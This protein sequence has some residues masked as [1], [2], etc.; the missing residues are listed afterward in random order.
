MREK[1]ERRKTIKVPE[2]KIMREK[3]QEKTKKN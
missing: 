3:L 2:I 1:S